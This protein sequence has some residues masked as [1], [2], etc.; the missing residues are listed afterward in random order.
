MKCPRCQQESPAD[1]DFC[2]ECG[3]KLAVVC[4]SCGTANT[5]THKFCKKCGKPLSVSAGLA[6]GVSR[7]TSPGSYTPK[8]LADRILT[9][10]TAIEGERKQVTVLFCD[11]ADSTALAEDLGAEAMHRL[12]SRFFELALGEVHRFEGTVNQFLGDGFMA[13]FGAPVA[14]ED[15]VRR[16]VAAAVS[17]RDRLEERSTELTGDPNKKLFVRMG[18]NTGPVVVGRIGDDLRMDYTAVGD[19]TNLAARLQQLADPG[20][21]LISGATRRQIGAH[22]RLEALP[23][24]QVKGKAAPVHAYRVLG[25]APR[26]SPLEGRWERTLTR[27]VGREPE[28]RVL[29]DLLD[30]AGRGHGQVVGVV[31]EPGV[32]KSRLLYEFRLGLGGRRA[33]Y[34]EGHCLSY[35]TSVPYLP[36]L[37]ILRS[38]CGIADADEPAVIADKVRFATEEVGLDPDGAVPYLLNLLGVK[39]S[40]G[41]VD[42]LPPEVIKT[43]T[44][45]TLRQLVAR[46]SHR[47]PTI[48]AI[49]DAHWIDRPS[50]EYFDSLVDSLPGAAILVIS[51]YRQGYRPPWLDRSYATQLSLRPLSLSE[52]QAVVKSVLSQEQAIDT[53]NDLILEKAEGNPFFIE[54]LVRAA[55][56]HL[57][58][59]PAFP[60]P[61]TIQGV[62]MARIDRLPED[63]KH[64]LQTASVAGREVPSR[65]L[66]GLWQGPLEST[67]GELIHREFLYQQIKSGERVYVFKHALTQDVA[68]ESLLHERRCILHAHVVE[69]VERLYADRRVDHVE[70]LA[71][72]AVRGEAFECA[73]DYLRQAATKAHARGALREALEW[74]EQALEILPRLPANAENARRAIDVRLHLHLPLFAMGQVPRLVML[75]REAEELA[76]QINDESRLGRIVAFRGMHAWIAA[77]YADALRLSREALQIATH[78]HDDQVRILATY[79]LGAVHYA[80]GDYQ[81]AINF[82]LQVVDG[83][84]TDFA[85]RDLGLSLG[86]P[87]VLSC[88]WL[89]G[90]LTDLGEFTKAQYWAERASD[91][92]DTVGQPSAQA[93]AYSWQGMAFIAKG[94][95]GSAL[96]WLERSVE[97]T[98]TLGIYAWLPA[99]NSVYGWALA[100]S[101]RGTEALPR[102]ERSVTSWEALGTKIYLSAFYRWWA[103]GLL[104]AGRVAEARAVAEKAFALATQLEERGNEAHILCLLGDIAAASELLDFAVAQNLYERS[105]KLAVELRMRPRL[106]HCHAGLGRLDRRVGREGE[107]QEHLTT[108][109]TMYRDMGMTYWVEQAEAEMRELR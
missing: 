42:A 65:L 103:E 27:F 108:A 31:G 8:H 74:L 16:A 30:E 7:F 107:A 83:A 49:E 14:H 41:S 81:A 22:G 89:V 91:A 85:R 87:Y 1:A 50:E 101:G 61:D 78:N 102:L 13:L 105:M 37:D 24:L 93:F 62:L 36:V 73:V 64:L 82:L 58:G 96:S 2:P 77:K 54:E 38:N 59:S 4:A 90:C 98:E 11:I 70:Q 21:I 97:L 15:H 55:G 100:S 76:R 28:L 72:H 109:T 9:S 35:G 84:D 12:L 48:F 10:R 75:Y 68:Y 29:R 67:V 6:Q 51:T 18:L 88:G 56:E 45:E 43:R 25:F 60:V 79:Y 106:A 20:T 26:R 104:F 66:E 57:P 39:D 63:A 19:T 47:R 53:V 86:S 33:T 71:H 23:P 52:S 5:P 92:A 44:L 95:F 40:T 80:I 69:V 94:D 46:G 99:A 3:A 32:G 34:L 17:F